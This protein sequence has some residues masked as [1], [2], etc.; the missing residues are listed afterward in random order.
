[1]KYWIGVVSREHVKIGVAGGFCQLN[2]G[3]AA[4]IRRL[5]PEDW[6]IYYSPK[7][8]LREGEPIK[9]FTAI[10]KIKGGEPYAVEMKK[11]PA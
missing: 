5:T 11:D 4:P 2:H 9:A 8:K 1:M 3:K 7:T 10:G 6:L